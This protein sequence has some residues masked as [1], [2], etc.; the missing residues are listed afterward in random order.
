MK[1]VKDLMVPAEQCATVRQEVTV[2]EALRKFKAMGKG[3][4]GVR[5]S[6]ECGA[7]LVVDQGNRAIGKLGRTD[8]VMRLDPGYRRQG[9]SSA[10]AHT[11]TAG[12]SPALLRSLLHRYSAWNESFETRC[13]SVLVL[14]VEECMCQPNSSECVMDSDLLEVAVHKLTISHHQ[15]LL[16]VGTQGIVGILSL[17]DVFREIDVEWGTRHGEAK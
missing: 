15:S 7:L 13:Q 12:L 8:I 6:A 2:G 9:D 11:A 1:L 14:T 3:Q 17:C 5:E 10:I 16:V 4:S